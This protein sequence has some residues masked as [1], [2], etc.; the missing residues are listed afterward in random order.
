MSDKYGYVVKTVVYEGKRYYV[1]GK[2]EQEANRKLGA[3]EAEL[4]SGTKI[5]NQ[6]TTVKKWA[7]EW[8]YMWHL[9]TSQKKV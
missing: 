6:K 7:K 4:K 9:K 5:L 3:L 8:M 2:T 1:R